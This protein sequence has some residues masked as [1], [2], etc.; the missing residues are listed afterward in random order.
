MEVILLERNPNLGNVGDVVK[1][2]SGYGRNFLLPFGK[3]L[4]ATEQNKQEFEAK[5][6]QI[7]KENN[8][9][10]HDA[11]VNSAKINGQFLT[12]IRQAGE[13][14]RLYGAVSAKDISDAASATS[15]LEIKRSQVAQFAPVKALGIYTIKI[16]LHPEV[17]VS[18]NVNVARSNSE[19]EIAK[20]E[21]LSPEKKEAAAAEATAESSEATEEASKPKKGKK[22]IAKVVNVELEDE[23]S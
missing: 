19:A 6:A 5:K 10:K 20:K 12:L 1:V 14:G 2:K 3:A 4:R 23:A 13:D 15:S 18:V 17:I 11:E 16:S 21:F 8:K 9:K 7:E 22:K